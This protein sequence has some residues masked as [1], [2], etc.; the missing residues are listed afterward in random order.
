MIR[1]AQ[2][3]EGRGEYERELEE[4]LKSA[5][6][7]KRRKNEDIAKELL[8]DLSEGVVE[9]LLSGGPSEA[10]KVV[11]KENAEKFDWRW[12]SFGALVGFGALALMR[13]GRRKR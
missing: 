6:E 1:G 4:R 10:K 3:V 12:V 7:A 13:G 9:G 11:A 5:E 2:A 8:Q